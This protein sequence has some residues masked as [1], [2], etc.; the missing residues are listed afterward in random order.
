MTFTR[1]FSTATFAL[2][3]SLA[4][5][6]HSEASDLKII[7]MAVT[8]KIVKGN[9]IDA[10]WRISSS[11]VKSLYCFTRT[12]APEATDTTIK[13]TWYLNDE[14]VHEDVMPV[15]GKRWRTYSMISVK[16]GTSGQYRCEA[17]DAAGEALKS[18]SF[19]MN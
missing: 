19:R 12:E 16:K 6:V 4:G 10:V 18:V 17:Q 14:V 11:S 7:E 13:H 5:P 1:L 8:T 2:L 15:K 9:P 3:I